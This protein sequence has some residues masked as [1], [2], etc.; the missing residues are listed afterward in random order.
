MCSC[1]PG[2]VQTAA[3]GHGCTGMKLHSISIKNPCLDAHRHCH[4]D[5]DCYPQGGSFNCQCRKG[6]RGDG[7][8]NISDIVLI[9]MSVRKI[10][11]TVPRPI[12]DA[13]TMMADSDVVVTLVMASIQSV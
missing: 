4:H 5:A 10:G 12:L 9:L 8:Y 13:S 7:R 3:K 2:W 11:I 6:F 1:K